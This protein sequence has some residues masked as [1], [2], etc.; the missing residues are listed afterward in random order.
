[1][2]IWY[3]MSFDTLSMVFKI[4]LL[5]Q[6]IPLHQKLLPFVIDMQCL[7]REM[8]TGDGKMSSRVKIM[9]KF[10]WWLC[11]LLVGTYGIFSK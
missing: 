9:N 2:N 5:L 3:L 1:M 7:V 10:N 6:I 4:L 11:L 8:A